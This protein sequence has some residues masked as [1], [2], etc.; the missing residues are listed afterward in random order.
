MIADISSEA[1]DRSVE[2]WVR[3]AVA[4]GA[5]SFADLVRALPGVYPA[6]VRRI[7]DRL[8]LDLPAGRSSPPS[9][10]E[11]PAAAWPI[12][13]PLD[14]DWRFTPDTTRDLVDRCLAE[15]PTTVALL[16][17]PSLVPVVAAS[18]RKQGVTLYDRNQAVL[19]AVANSYPEVA[20][21][22]ADLVCGPPVEPAQVA[23]TVA[24]PPWYPEDARAFLWA[25]ARLTRVG[26][27]VLLSLPPAGTRPGVLAEREQ[28][29]TAAR[30]Y[31]LRFTSVEPGVLAYCSPLFER[32]ALA[33]AGVPAVPW[34]WRRGD[35]AT[36]A[37]A[38]HPPAPRPLPTDPSEVWVEESVGVVRIKLRAG[39]GG[40]FR[41]PSLS[42]VVPG[43]MLA[44]VSR[45]E[46]V[47]RRAD[48]WTSG[49]RVFRCAGTA[50]LR[51]I[52]AALS[53]GEDAEAAVAVA[54]G[55]PLLPVETALVRQAA[56]QIARLVRL[57][58]GEL[59]EDAH[60]PRDPALAA[61]V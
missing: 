1:F 49:N 14:F 47:R 40:D 6:D 31:G 30:V 11:M 24:D 4:H 17:T 3:A 21:V 59:T 37:V 36:F 13:H 16:G 46:P 18:D 48:V 25:A 23:L 5:H 12:E 38:E 55:R 43:D 28:L 52:V 51:T 42:S 53:R 33:A 29:I 34:D 32:N 9:P 10:S 8:R 26:G 57:E 41:D 50:T 56:T 7:A 2:V 15:D 27:R 45:R 60:S 19:T 58:E 20:A 44:T 54:A 22:F 35:L 39:S 61:T